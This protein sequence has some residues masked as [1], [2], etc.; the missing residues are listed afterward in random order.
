MCEVIKQV[1]VGKIFKKCCRCW[2]NC[3]AALRKRRVL[4]L[5]L[6]DVRVVERR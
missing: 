6:A 2:I 1:L 4:L 5:T 3:V